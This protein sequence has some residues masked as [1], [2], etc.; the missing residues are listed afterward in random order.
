[1]HIIFL[2][3]SFVLRLLLLKHSAPRFLLAF[4][5]LVKTDLNFLALAFVERA[6]VAH[7]HGVDGTG[8]V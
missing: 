6:L 2:S 3:L 1:M 8:E 5:P 4:L 7:E